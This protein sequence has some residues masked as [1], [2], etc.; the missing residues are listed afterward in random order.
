MTIAISAQN[1]FTKQ[2]TGVELYTR[3]IVKGLSETCGA[4]DKI[5][6]YVKNL[7]KDRQ[8][9]ATEFLHLQK[10]SFKELKF[11]KFF[12]LIGVANAISK[13]RPDILF[14]PE[15]VVPLWSFCKIIFVVHGIELK[16]FPK[17]YSFLSRA[18]LELST[19]FSIKRSVAILAPS[20]ATKND[21]IKYYKVNPEK[22]FVV[23]HG[24]MINFKH[25]EFIFGGKNLKQILFLGRIEKRKN[26]EILIEAFEKIYT[27]F[28]DTSLIFA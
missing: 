15:S 22:I 6:V 26:L 12:N 10:V 20:Q 18:W 19:R 14:C 7:P 27:K 2:P 5:I 17:A 28:P 23:Q 24:P 9:E 21:L 1:F 25:T 4:E 3:E 13:D 11:K 8:D 16:T